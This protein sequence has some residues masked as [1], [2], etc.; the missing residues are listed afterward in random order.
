MTARAGEIQLAAPCVEIAL[1][2]LEGLERAGI[3]G[4]PDVHRLAARGEGHV[5]GQRGHL[6]LHIGVGR[7]AIGLAATVERELQGD[8][9]AFFRVEIGIVLANADA[10]IR[11]AIG[12][13]FAVLERCRK[14]L[15]AG[16]ERELVGRK[17]FLLLP[18]PLHVLVH[19]IRTVD[20]ILVLHIWKFPEEEILERLCV[21]GRV[22]LVGGAHARRG[23]RDRD[24]GGAQGAK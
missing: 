1:A 12:V 17:L 4:N 3:I 10:A 21:G 2:V 24:K 9:L 6:V 23:E 20:E 14:H 15:L 19:G 13:G 16:I 22:D 7:L 11:E 5:G 18:L 8:D